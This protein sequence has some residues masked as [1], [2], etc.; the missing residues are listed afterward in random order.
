[1]RKIHAAVLTLVAA[2]LAF[3]GTAAAQ[4]D[5]T[6]GAYGSSIGNVQDFITGTAAG[7]LFLLAGV[8][9]AVMVGLR[10]LKRARSAA[11]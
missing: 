9:V 3:T 2:T 6:N 7:P 11:S 4:E 8:V 1:M 10:W 5:P